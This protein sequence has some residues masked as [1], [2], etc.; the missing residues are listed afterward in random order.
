MGELSVG[1]IVLGRI[2]RWQIVRG[3]IVRGGHGYNCI[4]FL[5]MIMIILLYE[6]KNEGKR[7]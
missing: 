5:R 1:R 7:G 4:I 6:E 2:D 3:Q